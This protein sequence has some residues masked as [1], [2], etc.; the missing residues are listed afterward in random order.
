MD[1]FCEQ[2]AEGVMDQALPLDP[3]LA[4]ERRAF[5]PQRKV[6]FAGGIL[7]A[8]AAMRFAVVNQLQPGRGKGR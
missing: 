7:P 5:N 1:S 4:G 6:T 8:V 3:R 2:V